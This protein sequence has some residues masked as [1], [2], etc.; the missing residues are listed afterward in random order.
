MDIPY[1]PENVSYAASVNARID[2]ETA[3]V[4]RANMMLAAKAALWRLA[5]VGV[6]IL[7]LGV[8]TGLAFFGYSFIS[9]K[10]ASLDQLTAAFAK[11]LQANTLRTEGTVGVKPDATVALAPGGHV[12]IDPS[13]SVNL[14]PGAT[15]S[16]RPGT[17]SLAPDSKLAVNSNMPDIVR[18]MQQNTPTNPG[19]DPGKPALDFDDVTA[20]HSVMFKQGEV[21]SGWKYHSSNNFT[22][23]YFQFCYYQERDSNFLEHDFELATNGQI[24]QQAD[25]PLNI[26]KAEAFKLCVWHS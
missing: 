18:R 6:V 19:A 17:V 11:A 22:T 9:D 15:V 25:D 12:A 5:G 13:A 8:A 26:D 10:R 3:N 20:F 1:T 24:I 16:M 2:A 7:S 23:P 4:R 21:V 14:A